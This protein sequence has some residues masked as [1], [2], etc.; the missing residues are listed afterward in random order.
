MNFTNL[1]GVG[2]KICFLKNVN[3]MWLL[4]QCMDEW[5]QQGV[6]WTL[7]DLISGCASLPAPAVPID[8]NDPQLMIP[9]H[10][11]DNINSQLERLGQPRLCLDGSGPLALANTIFHSIAARYAEVL[12]R[13]GEIA[14]KKLKRLFIVGGGSQNAVLNRLTAERTGLEVIL[15]SKESA[16]IGNFAVQLATF[17]DD[18]SPSTGV[19]ASSVA[20]WAERMSANSLAQ[21]S[22][23]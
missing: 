12:A 9:G 3:G 19:T 22:D 17:E 13:I 6:C 10:A 14:G 18:W 2:G 5:K 4:R 1:G 23:R 15:G 11:I 21:F 8:V 7:E 16:T 20:K